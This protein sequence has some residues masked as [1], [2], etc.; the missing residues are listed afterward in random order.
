MKTNGT[1]PEG[2]LVS[3][4]DNGATIQRYFSKKKKKDTAKQ[5]ID[6]IKVADIPIKRNTKKEFKGEVL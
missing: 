2:Y 4:K 3:V 1:P 5:E 6:V